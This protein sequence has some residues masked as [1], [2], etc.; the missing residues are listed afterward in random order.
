MKMR[1]NKLKYLLLILFSAMGGILLFG[2]I[3]LR[4]TRSGKPER[5]F[6]HR[7]LAFPEK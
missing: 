2:S 5:G 3:P 6:R 4:G 1:T 7:I